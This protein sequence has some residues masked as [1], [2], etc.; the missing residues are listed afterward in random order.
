MYSS[1]YPFNK[2]LLLRLIFCW[3]LNKAFF[4]DSE[5]FD[6]S[7]Q[8]WWYFKGSLSHDE[9]RIC[10]AESI[11]FTS[12]EITKCVL[13]HILP[14]KKII[15]NV[16]VVINLLCKMLYCAIVLLMLYLFST[17]ASI[18]SLFL[19]ALPRWIFI[20][21]LARDI[22]YPEAKS[23]PASLLNPWEE[24]KM[25]RKTIDSKSSVGFHA[26]NVNGKLDLKMLGTAGLVYILCCIY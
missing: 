10:M 4:S 8:C 5:T 6:F 25:L 22:F 15:P 26:W 24:T 17:L 11:L 13:W 9:I 23:R 18:T 20:H 2:D 7:Q 1:L 14:K 12:V 3:F 19:F 21:L 16:F